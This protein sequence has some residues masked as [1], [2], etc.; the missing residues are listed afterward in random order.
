MVLHTIAKKH[1]VVGVFESRQL[2]EAARAI[3]KITGDYISSIVNH[4][5]MEGKEGSTLLL[6]RV[7]NTLCERV[8]LVRI[9]IRVRVTLP[10]RDRNKVSVMISV[11]VRDVVWIRDMV[12]EGLGLELKSVLGLGLGQGKS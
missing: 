2:T 9:G 6:H 8:L 3:D 11:W 7:P 10:V 1:V 4:G 12:R 5:D